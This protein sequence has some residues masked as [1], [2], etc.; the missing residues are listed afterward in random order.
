MLKGEND[1][2]KKKKSMLSECNTMLH[3][4]RTHM[5]RRRG[6]LLPPANIPSISS[7]PIPTASS[8]WD[9]LTEAETVLG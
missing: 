3:D 5:N 8:H 7:P 1:S 4:Q 9:H 2:A 6:G